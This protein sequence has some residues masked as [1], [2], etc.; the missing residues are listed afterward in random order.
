[1]PN[2]RI[3]KYLR[4]RY[5]NKPPFKRALYRKALEEQKDQGVV[6]KPAKEEKPLPE[7]DFKEKVE[8]MEANAGVVP[9]VRK[10][11]DKK[12]EGEETYEP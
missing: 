8:T 9:I 2:I 4:E 3:P 6:E 7:P 11:E 1:M 12:K 10:V 5:K